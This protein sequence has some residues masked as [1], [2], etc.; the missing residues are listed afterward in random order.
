MEHLQYLSC[1]E[2]LLCLVRTNQPDN[3]TQYPWSL[4][5]NS[6]CRP[7][8]IQESKNKLLP[9]HGATADSSSCKKFRP[10]PPFLRSSVC[11]SHLES[12]RILDPLNMHVLVLRWALHMN[13]F[14]PA[15]S[16][17]ST[18]LRFSWS[19]GTPRLRHECT[20]RPVY[21]SGGSLQ[22]SLSHASSA[23]GTL[24]SAASHVSFS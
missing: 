12:T 3:G 2:S 17:S 23:P 21:I 4:I 18:W 16:S 15:A 7:T 9:E 5:L 24:S 19:A 6:F 20:D 22:L 13:A 11:A 14:T 1:C 8:F 10:L